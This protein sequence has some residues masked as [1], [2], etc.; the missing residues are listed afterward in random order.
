MSGWRMCAMDKEA[1]GI[2]REVQMTIYDMI[3]VEPMENPCPEFEKLGYTYKYIK[4]MVDKTPHYTRYEEDRI[5][6]TSEGGTIKIQF[7]LGAHGLILLKKGSNGEYYGGYEVFFLN[8]E[9]MKCINKVTT[10][11]GWL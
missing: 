10:A 5:V 6:Y 3:D 7:N 1:R 4:G 8:I 11:L 2:S 9:I